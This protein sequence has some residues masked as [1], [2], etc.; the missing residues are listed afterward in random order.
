M[1]IEEIHPVIKDV[2]GTNTN[3]RDDDQLADPEQEIRNG[4]ENGNPGCIA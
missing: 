4:I 3:S 1:W 2:E